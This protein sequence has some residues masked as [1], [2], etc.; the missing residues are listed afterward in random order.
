MMIKQVGFLIILMVMAACS[1]APAKREK[2]QLSY[3]P[4]QLRLME[5]DEMNTLIGGHIREFK[6]SKDVKF[7]EKALITALSRP[8]ADNILDREMLMIENSFERPD[9]WENMVTTVIER[10]GQN[11]KDK[12]CSVQDE[13]SYTIVLENILSQFRT[14]FNKTDVNTDFE[15]ASI[16]KIADMDLEVSEAAYREA[17][18]NAMSTLVSPSEIAERLLKEVQA[19]PKSK[20]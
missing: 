19:L 18:L 9:E 4:G 6:K 2:S 12:T 7:A 3:T 13:V 10:A 14:E 1:S 8:D 5:V 11:L 16:K 15:L 17:K 20:N